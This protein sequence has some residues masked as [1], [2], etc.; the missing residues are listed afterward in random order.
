MFLYL[1]R[2]FVCSFLKKK[3]FRGQ[4]SWPLWQIVQKGDLMCCLLQLLHCWLHSQNMLYCWFQTWINELWLIYDDFLWDSSNE[5][6]LCQ[7][8]G[9]GT[10]LRMRALIWGQ[11]TSVPGSITYYL[12]SNVCVFCMH[13][14]VPHKVRIMSLI[15]YVHIFKC[16]GFYLSGA[17]GWLRGKLG[18]VCPILLTLHLHSTKLTVA[19]YQN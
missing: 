17:C 19:L 2:L 14:R 8:V 7:M 6:P 9:G 15:S 1:V 16:Q 13:Y 3:K 5:S 18:I 11:L 12:W 10:F 4:L